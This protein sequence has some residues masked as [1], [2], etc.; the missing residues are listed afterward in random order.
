MTL[1]CC[2]LGVATT[3]AI[4]IGPVFL[5][6]RSPLRIAPRS[7][8]PAAVPGELQRLE[9]ALAA[10]QGA[11]RTVRDQIPHATPVKVAEFIDSH[12]LMLE[13][14]A[15]VDPAR[16]LI[17]ERLFSAEWALE[18]HRMTLVK[19]FEEMEDPYLRGRRDDL[20]HVVQHILGF[21]LDGRIPD[22]EEDTDLNGCVV[23]AHDISPA[24]TVVLRQR[25]VV[26]LVT[27]YGSPLSHTAIL[28]R[29]LNLP[30][31]VGVRKVT[32]YFRPGETVVVDDESG[33]VLAD[34]DA[35]ILAHYRQR[36]RVLEERR[37]R[38]RRLVREPS[39]SADGTPVSLLGNLDLPEDTVAI[40]ANG[41]AGVGLY[42][43]E[44]LYMNRDRPPD[45][46]EQL[47]AYLEVIRG[48]EGTPVTIRTLDLG[49]DKQVDGD[50]ATCPLA[51]NPAL[52]LRAIRLCLKQPEL[53]RPQLRA[54][55]RAS[56]FG[57]VR[58]M[59]PMLSHIREL[60]SV[61]ALIEQVGRELDR[62]GLAFDPHMPVGGMIEV[63]AA[64]LS[65]PAFTHRLDFLSIGTNDLIQ[66]T[67]AID[68][69]DDTVS[70]LYDPL[71]PAI[72]RLIRMTIEAGRAH[73]IP[74]SMCGEMAG[75]PR[76]V[77][78][79]LG[80][81]LREFSMQPGS[82]LEIK[83]RVRGSHIPHLERA[84]GELFAHLEDHEPEQFAQAIERICS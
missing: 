1:S 74:V 12:L 78:L 3:R 5:L 73:G 64:A 14:A 49:A 53:F 69:M 31:V 83:E 61:L 11:L 16:A 68:R 79:L 30:M 2:G 65:A 7:I 22:P 46:E 82:L 48:L 34:V 17:R 56:A 27:E 9:A 20:D 50:S 26:A 40:R 42:R 57:P 24:D 18:Q 44:F 81:G 47:A 84:T 77:P 62:E 80:L 58:L 19:A 10:A 36:I 23:I 63:P 51:C 66:Y 15:L 70:Y 8:D 25:R 59:I 13:D 21:L 33:V 41:A 67:L 52:G 37:A 71:H 75:T 39:L 72:L 38:L 45:E 4:A 29:S 28:A 35:D 43:T 55:L 6:D 32:S 76:Y 60:D 54:I